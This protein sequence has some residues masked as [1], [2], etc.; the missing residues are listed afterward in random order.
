M[1]IQ[2]CAPVYLDCNATAPMEPV[3]REKV[4]D[5]MTREVGNPSSRTHSYGLQAKR[6]VQNA[7][8]QVAEVMN[9]SA[10]EVLF[11]S[12]ATESN[13]IAILGLAKYAQECQRMHIVTTEIEHK[14][15]LEPVEAL[16]QQGFSVT[17][18]KP[19]KDGAV[20]YLDVVD[21]IRPD[22]LLVSVMHVNNET[23][24][25]QPIENIAKAL[26]KSDVYFH[27]DA[28]QAC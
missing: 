19:G 18:V 2:N 26:E 9:A 24:A 20:S 17:Y 1:N 16:E 4:I 23:G 25:I 3:V 15:V 22:T 10:D 6:A 21:A 7:R 14:S 11:T 8:E 27:V 5:W 13:N 28:A 12:G